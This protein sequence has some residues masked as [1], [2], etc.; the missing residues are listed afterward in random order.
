M[1][2]FE[3]TFIVDPVLSGDELK[4]TVDTYTNMLKNEGCKIVAID[5]I[6]LK[7]LA[8]D[9][10]KRSSGI[11]YTIEFQSESGEII[12]KMEL[13]LR[14]DERIM[15]FL[16]VRLDKFGVK[17]NEDKRAGKIAKVKEKV[18]AETPKAEQPA[19]KPSYKKEEKPVEPVA[20]VE[21]EEPVNS[22]ETTEGE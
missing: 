12:A 9:I 22:V 11:Y 20:A 2:Q 10:N 19:P 21:P 18:K 8:Y 15:R 4:S 13:A 16:T 17:Y 3:V 7:Q 14:R 6:G 5:E 1:K